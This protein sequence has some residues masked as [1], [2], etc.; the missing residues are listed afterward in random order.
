MALPY[1]ARFSR[2]SSG[3]PGIRALG[4]GTV[5]RGF[6]SRD[7]PLSTAG[8]GRGAPT[9][10]IDPAPTLRTT[11]SQISR[12][13]ATA[14]EVARLQRQPGSLGPVVVAADAVPIEHRALG[15]RGGSGGGRSGGR[16]RPLSRGRGLRTAS[17]RPTVAAVPLPA[18]TTAARPATEASKPLRVNTFT[19]VF[20]GFAMVR[21]A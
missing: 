2:C 20:P 18:R 4:G 10:G 21:P 17:S 3:R 14:A 5:E 12:F 19:S 6:E 13:G 16:R 7:Q 9:G 11:F 8:S 1:S 15:S